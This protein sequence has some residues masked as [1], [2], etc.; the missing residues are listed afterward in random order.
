MTEPTTRSHRHDIVVI[1]GG[2][3]A[4]AESLRL[5]S[6]F[7]R[8]LVVS[9]RFGGCCRITGD[10]QLQS[11]LPEL[12]IAG[13][14][15]DLSDFLRSPLDLRPTGRQYA[16]Y[17]AHCFASSQIATLR[18]TVD[19]LHRD[20]AGFL[21]TVRCSSDTLP[22]RAQGVVLATG[23]RPNTPTLRLHRGTAIQCFDAYD[24]L[25]RGETE[26]FRKRFV[27][28]VGSGNSAYQLAYSMA[29]FAS[30]VTILAKQYVGFYPT[31]SR[32][33]FALRA[34]SLPTIELVQKT[35]DAGSVVQS[36]PINDARYG[37]APVFLHLYDDIWEDQATNELCARL[38]ASR[39]HTLVLSRSLMAARSRGWVFPRGDDTSIWRRGLSDLL[40]VHAIGLQANL[41]KMPWPDVLDDARR[42]V[43]HDGGQTAVEGLYVA[44][45]AAGY[46]SVNRME[47]VAGII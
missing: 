7:R 17:I 33:H 8:V 45:G 3:S 37:L 16:D 1:G 30:C 34:P 18:G 42:F 22:L 20:D 29:R 46:R 35:A 15:R 2:P 10:M 39:N 9:D 43:R 4:L 40:L 14:P 47:P 28:I 23:L 24:R 25:A 32:D 12:A 31:E 21:I 26:F 6:S 44:G 19:F 11:Y 27:C 41:P 38:P 36:G 13:A 5:R